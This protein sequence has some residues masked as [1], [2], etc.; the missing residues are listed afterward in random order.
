MPV[1]PVAA[2]LVRQVV[3]LGSSR[4]TGD[5]DSRRARYPAT[6][7]RIGIDFT[8]LMKWERR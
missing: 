7:K 6:L 3:S 1:R 5:D 8:P 4:R 2:E